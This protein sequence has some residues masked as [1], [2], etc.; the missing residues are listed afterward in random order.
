MRKKATKKKTVKR[1][2]AVNKKITRKIKKET[3]KQKDYNV[4]I[5]SHKDPLNLTLHVI[6]FIIIVYGAWFRNITWVLAGFI[7]MIVG[8]LWEKVNKK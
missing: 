8:Y 5:F 2:R 1:K 4:L 3:G 7:P 6:G